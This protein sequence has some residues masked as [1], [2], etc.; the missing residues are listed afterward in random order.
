MGS[1]RMAKIALGCLGKYLR[2]SGAETIFVER[3]MFS[4]NVLDGI[5][6]RWHYARSFK[7]MQHLKEALARLQIEAFFSTSCPEY[8][9]ICVLRNLQESLA[10]RDCEKS[11]QLL[12]DLLKSQSS[13]VED[14][15]NFVQRR[16]EANINFRFWNTLIELMSLVENLI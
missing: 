16:S 9:E 13:L 1:F 14:F 12:N 10:S 15:N 5:L 11:Q 7:G 4:S 6:T 3:S 2:G 8:Q